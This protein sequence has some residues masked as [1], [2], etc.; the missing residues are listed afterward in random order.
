MDRFQDENGLLAHHSAQAAVLGQRFAVLRPGADG[1]I[2]RHLGAQ[3]HVALAPTRGV[4]A[5]ARQ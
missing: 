2:R 1:L 4:M 3:V 5:R